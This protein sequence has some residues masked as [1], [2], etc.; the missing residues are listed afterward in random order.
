MISSVCSLPVT[1]D[2][3]PLRAAAPRI[4][5]SSNIRTLITVNMCFVPH[6][7]IL[8]CRDYTP[9]VNLLCDRVARWQLE[10]VYG[11]RIPPPPEGEAGRPPNAEEFLSSYGLMRGYM[12]S[13]GEFW[14]DDLLE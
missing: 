2:F 3:V 10:S 12:T 11:I 6:S 5:A 1:R 8:S 9:P 7:L 13:Q 14:K 4:H